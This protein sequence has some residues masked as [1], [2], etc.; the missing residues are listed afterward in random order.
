MA[1]DLALLLRARDKPAEVRERCETRLTQRTPLTAHDAITLGLAL[2]WAC[3]V[4]GDT[5]SAWQAIERV[6][7]LRSDSAFTQTMAIEFVRLEAG[8]L[9]TQGR[10][11]AAERRLSEAIERYQGQ[12][13]GRLFG[14][15]GRLLEARGDLRGSLAAINSGLEDAQARGDEPST[16]ALLADRAVAL[17]ELGRFDEAEQDLSLA[18]NFAVDMRNRSQQAI[19]LHN[20]GVVN[21][22]RGRLSV[23]IAQFE[24]ASEFF[25]AAEDRVSLAHA[26]LDRS[27]LLFDAGLHQ[28]SQAAV[29]RSAQLFK[30]LGSPGGSARA[31]LQL[32]RVLAGQGKWDEAESVAKTAAVQL[33]EAEGDSL[34]AQRSLQ[35]FDAYRLVAA[36]EQPSEQVPKLD[37]AASRA[38]AND[39][40][41]L[42]LDAGMLLARAQRPDDARALFESVGR[43][44]NVETASVDLDRMVAQ[45]SLAAM[46][47][48]HDEAAHL[49][50]EGIA[51]AG[52]HGLAFGVSEL[53]ATVQ[54]RV[55]QL[56]EIGVNAELERQNVSGIIDVLE[57]S[58]Q[59]LLLPEP[60]LSDEEFGLLSQLGVAAESIEQ[61]RNEDVRADHL[62]R[63]RDLENELQ[64]LRRHHHAGA[65]RNART[66]PRSNRPVLPKHGAYLFSTGEMLYGA[67][68]ASAGPQVFEIG[69]VRDLRRVLAAL[70]MTLASL[71][72]RTAGPNP[73]ALITSARTLLRPLLDR[74]ED[75][76]QVVVVPDP[77]I[78]HI[79]WPLLLDA[80]VVHSPS[81]ASLPGPPRTR[82]SGC[83]PVVFAGPGLA[84]AD[85]EAAEIARVVPGAELFV[86]GDA[87]VAQ[88]TSTFASADSV[89]FATH[90]TFRQDN[91]LYSSLQLFGGSLTF[92]D[93]L[94]GRSPRQLVFSACDVGQNA[95]GS[96]MGIAALLFDRGC[97][98]LV[99]SAG[100]TSDKGASE[101][102]G[103]VYEHLG[104]GVA[105][106]QALRHSQR[107]LCHNDP[108][109][110]LFVA[111]G[112]E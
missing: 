24:Q 25:I 95:V 30:R 29:E 80:A 32:A 16:C 1:E 36:L 71:A 69:P 103:L 56:V 57:R 51:Y 59:V 101:L 50:A 4:Q 33:R 89:H 81:L 96:A 34:G 99:A 58:K 31:L 90:G 13:R 74:L 22:R 14:I 8:V 12:S 60:G 48:K 46:K 111:F 15:L 53:R 27:K 93:L 26:L 3:Y 107:E 104:C 45:A 102:M 43:S 41:S 105:L 72:G 112:G 86:G 84:Y 70:R 54:R 38:I 67:T 55:R 20:L 76:E 88:A 79:P 65:S 39:H 9:V 73:A 40:P 49:A 91:P 6:R 52:T 100:P 82:D 21:A 44:S 11:E 47:L 106:G 97:E 64:Q 7:E 92:F 110:A 10:S 62:R 23:A 75:L 35:L 87:T 63:R 17:L 5:D 109:L 78:G 94:R 42:A 18:G 98:A 83:V 2:G 108:S 19:V 85:Q 28:E 68:Y 77:S 66:T 61:S 37:A